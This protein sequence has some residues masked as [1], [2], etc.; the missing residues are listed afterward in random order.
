MSD[1]NK[2]KIGIHMKPELI[3]RVDAEYPLHGYSSRSSFV[4]AATEFYIGYLHSQS[5]TEFMNKTTLAFIENQVAKLD[6]KI[7]RQM[8]RMCVEMSMT[9]H[10]TASSLEVDD[11]TL[12]RLRKRCVKDVKTT[13][14]NIQYDKIYAF[15]HSLFDGE[16]EV[17]DEEN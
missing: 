9:A 8:F 10:V 5:D 3:S 2:S 6:A 14:G 4:S 17:Y 16:D 7:C 12:K 15:Q 13:I 1:N 11:E